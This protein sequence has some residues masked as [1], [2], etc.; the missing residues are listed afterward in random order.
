[1]LKLKW[2][3]IIHLHEGAEVFIGREESAHWSLAFS[4][5]SGAVT[6]SGQPHTYKD[7]PTSHLLLVFL[8]LIMQNGYEQNRLI[9][10]NNQS[11]FSFFLPCPVVW[12][13]TGK[14]SY[15][16]TGTIYFCNAAL[17]YLQPF[18]EFLPFLPLSLKLYCY[19]RHIPMATTQ[20]NT[21]PV[22]LLWHHRVLLIIP[23]SVMGFSKQN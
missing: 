8:H 13:D 2:R 9:A 23:K 7:N 20:V 18:G 19:K 22:L 5:L 15:R 12:T 16:P 14:Q 21:F 6:R 3:N 4:S 11:A 1:M 10:P 17:P